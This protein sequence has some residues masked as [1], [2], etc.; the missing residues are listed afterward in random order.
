MNELLATWIP[1]LAVA[2]FHFVW[3]GALVGLLTLAFLLALPRARPE[4]RYAICCIA[5]L[6]CAGLPL[7]NLATAQTDLGPLALPQVDHTRLRSSIAASNATMASTLLGW[8]GPFANNLSRAIVLLWAAGASISL[9][10][11]PVSVGWIRRLR[12]T[13]QSPQ[14]AIWQARLDLLSAG[15]GITR[16]VALRVVDGLDSP[17]CAGWLRPVVFVPAALLTR[18]TPQLIEALL[19]HEL[20]HIRRHDYLVNVVQSFI[21]A[22]LFYHPV[23]WWLSRQIRHERELIA[24]HL[25]AQHTGKPRVLAHALAELTEFQAD[26][27]TL[28]QAATGGHVVIRIKR[29]VQANNHRAFDDIWTN[30]G[31]LLL[32]GVL[33]AAL[34]KLALTNIEP[35]ARISFALVRQDASPILGWGPDDDI[36]HAAAAVRGVAGNFI[37]VRRAGQEFVITDPAIV[38]PLKASWGEADVL[39]AQLD[40]HILNDNTIASAERKRAG[41]ARKR[42]QLFAQTE[43]YLHRV[44]APVAAAQALSRSR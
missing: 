33:A 22:V 15:F 20:A 34:A 31:A 30:L 41:L 9:L 24:D 1:A 19:A 25:A 44:V 10:R 27:P 26:V 42:D 13:P 36:D 11:L 2:L 8:T 32:F 35:A 5:L 29:L 7:L 6:I 23:T 3:Q 12:Q 28:A 43:R 14:Q 4:A 38:G 39:D 17:L 16:D 21:E 37:F 40:Q 18:M